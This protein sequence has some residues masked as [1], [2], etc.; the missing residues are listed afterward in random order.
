VVLNVVLR[1]FLQLRDF[2][3]SYYEVIIDHLTVS[4]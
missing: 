3:A 2:F 1:D 4:L